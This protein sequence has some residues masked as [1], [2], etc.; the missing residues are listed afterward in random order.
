MRGKK[1]RY[2]YNESAKNIIQAGKPLFETIKGKW[3]DL[4]FKNDNPIVLEL[5]CGRGEYTLG[6]AAQFPEKNFIGVDI[7][8]D[9]LW[10]GS[11]TAVANELTNVAFLRAFIHD[12]DHFFEQDEVSEIWITFPDPRP[13]DKDEKR[14]LTSE[15]FINLYRAVLKPDGWLKLKTDS[16]SLF[17]YTLDFLQQHSDVK[18]LT[19]TQNLDESN[20]ISDH[21]GI[22][23]YYE[24]LFSAQG[25][26]IKYL[27]TRFKG[28]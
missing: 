1:S 27:K 19:Y 24:R 23:T 13:K 26:K 17:E 10:K 16:T 15:R 18:D 28:K 21:F 8:G 3:A 20:L 12:L 11:S 22:T 6:L 7:K 4:Y 14:R 9:R 5:A 25:E 2:A